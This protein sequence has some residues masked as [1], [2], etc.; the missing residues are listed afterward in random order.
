[1]A[2]GEVAPEVAR[3]KTRIDARREIEIETVRRLVK[4]AERKG[5]EI[6]RKMGVVVR[7]EIETVKSWMGAA[8]SSGYRGRWARRY[9]RWRPLSGVSSRRGR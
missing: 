5:S 9:R 6:V 7:R 3:K 4:A 8:V 2:P 1:M